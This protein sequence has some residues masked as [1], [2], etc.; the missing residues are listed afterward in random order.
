MAFAATLLCV[1]TAHASP[2]VVSLDQCADQYVL[3][4]SPRETIVGLSYRADDADSH[5]RALAQ[6]LP[7]RRITTESIMAARP[8]LAV[9]YWG[10]DARLEAALATHGVK[11]VK[12]ED[13]TDFNGVRANVR[14]V[15]AALG[16]PARGETIVADMDR[17]LAASKDAWKGRSGLYLTP[18]GYTAGQGTFID[19]ILAAAG[20]RNAAPQAGFAPIRLE[21]VVLGPPRGYVLGFF[22][23]LSSAFERWGMGR[24][25]ALQKRLPIQTLASLPASTLSCPGWFAAEAVETLAVAAPK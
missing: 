20:V 14:T 17:R 19:R 4:L 18:S 9:R 2:R 3:A 25:R 24:H 22:D 8:T 23:Q 7:Q 12:I 6:G 10:G 16:Q 21:D 1:T 5:L 11:V 13:A 15:A